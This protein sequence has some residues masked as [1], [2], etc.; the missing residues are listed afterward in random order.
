MWKIC[1]MKMA[2]VADHRFPHFLPFFPEATSQAH[3]VGHIDKPATRDPSFPP[4]RHRATEA[5]IQKVLM[6][7]VLL[8]CLS[9]FCSVVPPTQCTL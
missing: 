1:N 8:V 4:A 9:T 5:L 3:S 2:A 7:Q 6:V